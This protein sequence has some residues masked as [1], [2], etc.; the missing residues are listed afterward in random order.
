MSRGFR[1]EKV[2]QI[3]DRFERIQEIG[4][5]TY[6][7]VEK[8]RDLETKEIVAVKRIK[9]LYPEH[10]FP[11]STLRE[12]NL[13][14]SLNHDNIVNIK[15]V[16][17]DEDRDA[18]LHLV[19]EYCEYDIYALIHCPE[20]ERLESI[21]MKSLM[22]QF[23]V[24][25]QFLAVQGI[26]H[27]DLKPANMFVTRGGVLKLGDF[28]LARRLS[29]RGRMT[30]QMITIWYRPPEMLLGCQEYG[31]EVDIWSAGCI[32]FEMATSK[33]LFQAKDGKEITT[34]Y[35]IFKVCGRPTDENWPEFK[36]LKN[37][38]S[39]VSKIQA[40]PEHSCLNDILRQIPS[41]FEGLADLLSKMIVMNPRRRITAEDAL[42]H[43]F[44]RNMK[45][46]T[47]P[48]NLPKI[49]RPEM[50]ERLAAE[51]RKKL[52]ENAKKTAMERVVPPR[53]T[54]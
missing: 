46:D 26:V 40:F 15:A 32:L 3:T 17:Q 14:K 20:A 42:N 34:L 19:F 49:T 37:N 39:V 47:D 38:A 21:I 48:H 11:Y 31:P 9:N 24:A 54:D 27:R 4:G 25:L 13:L 52:R 8:C 50:H 29:R 51:R 41:E 10:G 45:A 30:H 6:G 33:V 23:L 53:T 22:K 16:I 18:G 44:F 1:V 2:K 43:P 35:E 5:G 7:I 36:N 12:V 28:G